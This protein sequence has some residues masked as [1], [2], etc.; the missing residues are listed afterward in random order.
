MDVIAPHFGNLTETHAPLS[1]DPLATI[2]V[3]EYLR[4]YHIDEDSPPAALLTNLGDAMLQRSRL[5]QAVI[6]YALAENRA[7]LLL[8]C[9][10]AVNEGDH[11]QAELAIELAGVEATASFG[12]LLCRAEVL[13]YGGD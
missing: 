10:I 11:S 9:A 2:G 3:W 13:G 4:R 7:R 5:D 1:E 6:A 12:M 8:C